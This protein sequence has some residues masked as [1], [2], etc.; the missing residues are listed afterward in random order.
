[1][2]YRGFGYKAVGR[3]L[4][5]SAAGRNAKWACLNLFRIA[6]TIIKKHVNNVNERESTGCL[7]DGAADIN[8]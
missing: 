6:L 7:F 1:M 4:R 5:F 2:L 3:G 8:R